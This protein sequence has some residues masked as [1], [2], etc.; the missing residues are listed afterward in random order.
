MINYKLVA[1]M[2]DIRAIGKELHAIGNNLNQIAKRAN[3]T[4]RV[5][6]EDLAEIRRNQDKL[7]DGMNAILQKLGQME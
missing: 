1:D 7:W 5:Y 3:E 6:A 4:G 2:D